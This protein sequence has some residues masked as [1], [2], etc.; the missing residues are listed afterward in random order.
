LNTILVGHSLL[1]KLFLGL[2]AD[3]GKRSMHFHL[4]EL[5]NKIKYVKN[6]KVLTFIHKD[7]TYKW[8]L[9]YMLT[10]RCTVCISCAPIV[11][12]L[13]FVWRLLPKYYIKLQ[14][15][16]KSIILCSLF[17]VWLLLDYS[18]L[19]SLLRRSAHQQG[20]TTAETF[21]FFSNMY[22]C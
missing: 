6:I 13:C 1:S 5:L 19:W 11:G 18:G 8:L 4:D 10:Q 21:I 22:E 14:D 7:D 2:L 9:L 15:C 12:S 20:R 17:R 16:T 3:R